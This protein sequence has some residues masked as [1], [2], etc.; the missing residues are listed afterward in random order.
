[1]VYVI[2]QQ[3]KLKDTGAWMEQILSGPASELFLTIGIDGKK[4]FCSTTKS[5]Q[6]RNTEG[7]DL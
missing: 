1:M 4:A 5:S 2:H 7:E 6:R 3:Y